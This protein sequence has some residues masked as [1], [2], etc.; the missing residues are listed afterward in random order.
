MAN[1]VVTV[2]A[3]GY[4]SPVAPGA[5]PTFGQAMHRSLC[6]IE[7]MLNLSTFSP[8]S[9]WQRVK[10]L[11]SSLWQLPESALNSAWNAVN[12][13]WHHIEPAVKNTI[14]RLWNA[15][16][17]LLSEVSAGLASGFSTTLLLLM[18]GLFAVGAW[19]TRK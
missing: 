18:A 14:N 8:T 19:E 7:Q 1:E 2:T 11:W 3:C 9:F 12:G 5:V 4:G 6:E 15:A 10:E 17:Q 13:A 16:K